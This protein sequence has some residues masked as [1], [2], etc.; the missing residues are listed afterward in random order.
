MQSRYLI[1]LTFFTFLLGA[2]SGEKKDR[3]QFKEEMVLDTETGDEYLLKNADTMTVVHIDGTSEPITVNST[4]FAGSEE[5]NE[6][7]ENYRAN[8]QERKEEL[9]AKEKARI[10]QER[11]E[12]YAAYSDEELE[13]KFEE[14]HEN[15][16]PFEQQMDIVAEL[17]NREVIL[18]IDAAELLE[19]DPEDIDM[20]MEYSGSNE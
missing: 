4:P 7:M 3:Y 15:G 1:L 12:R 20:D 8:L 17:V 9:L 13:A 10:K 18:E 19:I 14:L 16:A 2:C 6:M 11:K 5:L